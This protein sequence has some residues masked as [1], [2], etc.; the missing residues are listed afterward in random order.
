MN[1]VKR[2]Y[3]RS[4]SSLFIME[5]ILSLLF[6]ALACSICIQVAFMSFSSRHE[7]RVLNHLQELS[8]TCSE[9]LEGWT[10]TNADYALLLQEVGLLP[11][12]EP[13]QLYKGEGTPCGLISV[14]FDRSF[15]PCSAQDALYQLHLT[16]FRGGYQ[17]ALQASLFEKQED[18]EFAS[19]DLSF[20]T[21]FPAARREAAP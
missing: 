13:V 18:G 20:H 6:F 14:Y 2:I 5:M 17:K 16:L 3:S 8:V 15:S 19:T 7:A 12:I 1:R 21:A 10:G 11:V 4:K 9:I